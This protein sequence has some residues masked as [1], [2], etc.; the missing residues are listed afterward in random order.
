MGQAEK[1]WAYRMM[2]KL[3]AGYDEGDDTGIISDFMRE[4]CWKNI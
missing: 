4:R 1:A 3:L 2:V